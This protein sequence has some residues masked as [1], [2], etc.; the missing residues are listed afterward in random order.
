MNNG[1][2]FVMHKSCKSKLSANYQVAIQALISTRHFDKYSLAIRIISLK[3][4][5]F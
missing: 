5:A 3:F 1:G 4:L 2:T